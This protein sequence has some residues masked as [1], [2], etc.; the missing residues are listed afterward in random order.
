LHHVLRVYND[1]FDHMDGVTRASATKK[2]QWK[3]DLFFS[4]KLAQQKLSKYYAEV[5]RTMGTLL[6]SAQILDPFQKSQSCRMW[7][8]GMDIDPGDG[9][10]Y[11]NQYPE[12]FLRYV[13]IEYCAKRQRLPVNVPENV[14]SSNLIPAAIATRSGRSSFDPYDLSSDD[15]RYSTPNNVAERT[16]EQRDRVPPLLSTARLYL[17]S[18]PEALNNGGKLFQISM[19]TTPTQW[20]LSSHFAYQT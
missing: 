10:S 18:P 16:P 3:E 6:M 7:D 19:I 5:T 8:N 2:T 17:N 13:E 14:P 1:M 15:E 20:R 4:M 11:T 9:T 12:A